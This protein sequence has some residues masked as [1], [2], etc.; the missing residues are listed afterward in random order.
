MDKEPQMSKE[1]AAAYLIDKGNEYVTTKYGDENTPGERPLPYHNGYHSKQE[2]VSHVIRMGEIALKRGKITSSDFMLLPIAGAWHDAEQDLGPG[3]NED[4]SAD[5]LEEQLRATGV[6]SEDEISKGRNFVLATKAPIKDGVM[7]QEA[8]EDYATQIICDAD[9]FKVGADFPTY[10]QRSL[11]YLREVKGN[12]ELSAEDIAAFA[13]DQVHLFG[14]QEF[15]TEEAREIF[16]NRESNMQRSRELANTEVSPSVTKTIDFVKEQLKDQSGGHGWDH[17][18]RAWKNA[19]R[20]AL[21]EGDVDIELVELAT[22]LHDVAD[23]KFHGGDEEAGPR[24]A[25]EWLQ[26]IGIEQNSV[27]HVQDIIRGISF[28]G[29]GVETPMQTKEGMIVQDA[30]RLDALGVIGIARAIAT[31]EHFKEPLYDPDIPPTEHQSHAEYMSRHEKPATT[32]NHFD[33]K[34]KH[35]PERMNTRSAKRI[36]QRRWEYMKTFVNRIKDEWDGKA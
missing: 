2:V 16:P 20:I 5:R 29:A 11:D 23:Y 1:K 8:T 3:Q 4:V 18:E 17:V 14:E 30:D 26:S 27:E 13:A 24:V 22:I 31:G 33:E 34:L 21:E 35:L 36:A 19:K 10:W 28:K 9:W 15:F 32:I 25:G 7:K 12:E 6:F